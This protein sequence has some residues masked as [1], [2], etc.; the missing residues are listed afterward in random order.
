MENIHRITVLLGKLMNADK[1]K[2]LGHK[3]IPATMYFSVSEKE[4]PG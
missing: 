3:K 1:I 4:S 2:I